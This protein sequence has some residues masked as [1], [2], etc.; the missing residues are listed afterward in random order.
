[1]TENKKTCYSG[2]QITSPSASSS[3]TAAT[4]RAVVRGP[5]N[6]DLSAFA[7]Y[8]HE[9]NRDMA[10]ELLA[11][12]PVGS[13][14]VRPS[15]QVA[16]LALSHRQPNGTV[17]HMLLRYWNVPTRR[18]YSKE[19]EPE[20]YASVDDLLHSLP[21]VFEEPSSSSSSSSSSV[22]TVAAVAAAANEQAAPAPQEADLDMTRFF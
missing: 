13:F 18:G 14:L 3:T 16:C 20:T 6:E 9:V 7:W 1:L 8:R 11:D 21:L 5:G 12:S 4:P 17:G 19:S 15:S 22:P 2:N 10:E